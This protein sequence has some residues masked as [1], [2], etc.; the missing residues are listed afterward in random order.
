MAIQDDLDQLILCPLL[1][2]YGVTL[3][4]DVLSTQYTNG[5]P[6]QRLDNVGAWHQVAALFR[7]KAQHQDYIMSFW[8]LHKVKPFAMRLIVDST[9]MQWY[10]CR[11]LGKPQPQVLGGGVFELGANLVVKPQPLNLEVDGNY[12][13]AYNKTGGDISTL[14][15]I[16][17]R[18]VNEDLPEDFGGLDA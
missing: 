10:E 14:N 16:L 7:H 17:E 13:W 6:R 5:P 2:G 3:G 15:N 18:L 11:F 8:R 12:V 9:S 4:D 1:D